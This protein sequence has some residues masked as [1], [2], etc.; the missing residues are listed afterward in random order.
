[1]VQTIVFKNIVYVSSDLTDTSFNAISLE[2]KKLATVLKTAKSNE[3]IIEINKNYITVRSGRSRAKIDTME[4]SQKI[5]VEIGYGKKI[6]LGGCVDGMNSLIHA[7]DINN[8]KFELNGMLLQ[9]KN[10]KLNMVATDTKRLA[11]IS[12]IST[13]EDMDIIIPKQAVKTL[14]KLFS[15]VDIEVESNETMFSV[16]SPFIQYSTKLISS[17]FPEYQ[18]IIPKKFSQTVKLNRKDLLEVISEAAIFETDVSITIKNQIFS[19]MDISRNTEVVL[20]KDESIYLHTNIFFAVNSK[21]ILEFLSSTTSETVE[22]CFNESSIPFVLKDDKDY[23]EIIMP[24]ALP[25]VIETEDN[26]QEAV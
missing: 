9:T 4:K 5:D 3:V 17:C 25:D 14:C 18:R 7:I 22:L 6:D 8:P 1:M 11:V 21:Y 10:N 26:V 12:K 20:P 19:A 13:A 24:M 15:D 16:N 2:G 23:E